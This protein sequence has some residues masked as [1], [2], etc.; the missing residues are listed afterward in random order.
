MPLYIQGGL[1]SKPQ[2]F[3]HIFADLTDL[4]IFFSGTFYGKFVMKR[5]QNVYT[6]RQLPCYPTG[7]FSD[8]LA[9][10]L[11]RTFLDHLVVSMCTKE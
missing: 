3:V 1:K 10:S 7:L 5:L 4:Q 9:K 11:W 6:T 2:T 8:C